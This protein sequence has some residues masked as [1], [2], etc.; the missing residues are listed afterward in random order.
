MTEVITPE[1]RETLPIPMK[2]FGKASEI[3]DAVIWLLSDDSAYIT[4]EVIHVD[5][6]LYM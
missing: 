3:A 1:M 2:R 6:G 4:G 5:G